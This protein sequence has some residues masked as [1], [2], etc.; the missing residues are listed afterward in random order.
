V[1]FWGKQFTCHLYVHTHTHVYMHAHTDSRTRTLTDAHIHARLRTRLYTRMFSY[2]GA[3]GYNMLNVCAQVRHEAQ[4]RADACSIHAAD[5]I[6]CRLQQVGFFILIPLN[7]ICC[8]EHTQICVLLT[9]S[10]SLFPLKNVERALKKHPNDS[11]KPSSVG[12]VLAL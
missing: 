6:A 11:Y 2:Q 7:L 12:L 9:I 4:A 3:Q 8:Q 10:R 5:A 1:L